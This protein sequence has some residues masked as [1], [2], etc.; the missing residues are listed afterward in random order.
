MAVGDRVEALLFDLGRVVIEL[1]SARVHA[2]WAELAGVSVAEIERR[3]RTRVAQ[4]EAFHRHECGEISD[5]A[6]FAHLR[7]ALE[8]DLTDDELKD[9]WNAIFVG[10]MPG[11][12]PLLALAG[13]VLPLYAFSNTNPAHQAC[14]SVR[15][16]ELLAS[17]RQVFV[18]NELGA[19]KPDVAAFRAVATAMGVAPARIL[20][21]DDMAANVAGAKASGMQA[22]E[23]AAVA[24]IELALISLEG[25]H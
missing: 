13:R 23:V 21:F 6:F 11:I 14:W 12:R 18:S 22:V 25:C 15:F 20:F 3:A 5:A 9:G 10:E 2:R 7:S 17:F 1:D 8:I 19:R 24:D 16:S 4:S